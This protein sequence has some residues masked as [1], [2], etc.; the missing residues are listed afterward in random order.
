M[1]YLC[2][3]YF[4]ILTYIGVKLIYKPYGLIESPFS[5]NY[6]LKCKG[7]EL[8]VIFLFAT[9]IIGLMPVLAIRLAILEIFCLIIIFRSLGKLTFSFPLFLYVLF[10]SWTLYGLSYTVAADYGVRMILKYIYPLLVAFAISAV[11]RDCEI[12]VSSALWARRVALFSIVVWFAGL[13]PL[14]S[15]VFWNRAA[16]VT[17]YVMISIISLTFY[18]YTNEKKKNIYLF[19]ITSA[20]P[21]IWVFRTNIME[22]MIG[23]A[24]FYFIKNHVKSLPVIILIGVMS[25]SSIF[26]IPAVKQKMF[27]H[28]ENVTFQKYLAGEVDEDDVNTSGRKLVWE[29]ITGFYESH[30]IKGNGTGTVQHYIYEEHFGGQKGGQ[31]HNDMLVMLADNGRVGLSL[32]FLATFGIFLHSFLVYR[33]ER[34]GAPI[35]M[36][37]LIAGPSAIAMFSTMYSD[38]TV[39]YSMCTLSYP[40]GFYGMML[41]LIKSKKYG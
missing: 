23:I 27:L 41:G 33:Q 13:I 16:L 7:N 1:Y 18:Y 6:L 20:I 31:T 26:L 29:I 4:I 12:F 25:V 30:P 11:V 40:W 37:A 21:F 3:L 39:S 15:G 19:L 9:G 14:F 32:Y 8:F 22:L 17:H 35:K 28:P 36:L 34:Y 2:Y 5:K 24:C 38:N 10:I